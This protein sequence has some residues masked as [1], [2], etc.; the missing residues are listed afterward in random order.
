MQR[1]RGRGWPVVP[2]RGAGGSAEHHDTGHQILQRSQF[3]GHQHDGGTLAGQFRQHLV[4]LG[5]ILLIDPRSGFVQQQDV[6]AL[7]EGC[8]DHD[9][10]LLS[11]RQRVEAVSPSAPQSDPIERL[12]NGLPVGR[13]VRAP[14][15]P[16]RDQPGP[17]HFAHRHRHG[18][19]GQE[20]L[21]HV[22]HPLPLVETT[23]RDPEDLR[24]PARQGL[25]SHQG[26]QQGCLTGSVLA[27]Q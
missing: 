7:G 18:T 26:P 22:T 8:G 16:R 1:C 24:G 17:H 6:G 15:G 2:D 13:T 19:R 9:P 25:Q 12:L 20:V 4:Q 23:D 10:A 3:V 5:D 21:G 27:Q 14:P 11:A